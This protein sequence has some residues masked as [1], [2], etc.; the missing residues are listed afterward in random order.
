M[1]PV[2]PQQ[3]RIQCEDEAH[4]QQVT[5]HHEDAPHEHAKRVR[6]GHQ[7][8]ELFAAGKQD[9]CAS[10]EFG[11]ANEGEQ[12]FGVEDG[13]DKSLGGRLW[14][15]SCHDGGVRHVNVVEVLDARSQEE[16]GVEVFE[17]SVESSVHGVKVFIFSRCSTLASPEKQPTRC[18][19]ALWFWLLKHRAK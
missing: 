9:A 6:E 15:A 14:I 4:D 1:R 12:K 2:G 3:P 16:R 13:Q 5:W 18:E 7:D 19:K 17:H 11:C 10:N 8:A